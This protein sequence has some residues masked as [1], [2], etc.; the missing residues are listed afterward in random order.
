MKA[1]KIVIYLPL[2][3]FRFRLSQ[4]E[5]FQIDEPEVKLC[6]CRN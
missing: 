1:L 6:C 2:M 4:R 5:I 3:F